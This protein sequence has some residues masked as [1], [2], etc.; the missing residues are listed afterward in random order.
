MCPEHAAAIDDAGNVSAYSAELLRR[1]KSEQFEEYEKLKQGW[2]LN[3]EQAKEALAAS[4]LVAD[5][6]VQDSTLH[7]GGEGGGA[8]S[9]GGGGG[10]A[11]GRNSRGGQGGPGGGQRIDDGE[12]TL[13]LTDVS[14]PIGEEIKDLSLPFPPGAGGGGAGA[15]GDDAK[16]GDGGGGGDQVS[17]TYDAEALREAGWDGRIEYKVAKGAAGAH[18]PGQ[19]GMRGEDSV[20]QFRGKNG[21]ILKEIRV[22]GGVP[23]R[24]ASSYLPEGVEEISA[25]DI[26]NGFRIT[27]LMVAGSVEIRDGGLSISSGGWSRCTVPQIPSDA[28]FNVA[29]VA[30]WDA[31]DGAAPRGIFLSLLHPNGHE[32]ACQAVHI[33]TDGLQD[34]IRC[35]AT[36]LGAVVDADGI[37]TVQARSG[38]FLLSRLAVR[39]VQTPKQV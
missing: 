21:V 15:I 9:A 29:C 18:L 13:P 36:Q 32:V 3:D 35:W 17:G 19:H 25:D 28:I 7:L 34:G 20:I 11:I 27:S 33:P 8:P 24:A 31:F 38:G 6:V 39:V 5:V 1:W 16:G 26:E 12:F 30:N 37:W 2:I 14:R 10:G 4:F 22:A 23:A